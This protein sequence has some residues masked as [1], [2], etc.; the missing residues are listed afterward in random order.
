MYY[1][2]FQI[3]YLNIPFLKFLGPG[4]RP[5]YQSISR[6]RFAHEARL[7]FL[8]YT[9]FTASGTNK[10][11]RLLL[12]SGGQTHSKVASRCASAA[13][14]RCA[15]SVVG[16]SLGYL[17]VVMRGVIVVVTVL[18]VGRKV[19]GPVPPASFALACRLLSE[20]PSTAPASTS[21][22]WASLPSTSHENGRPCLH[23]DCP[24]CALSRYW[25]HSIA[26][27]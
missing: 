23:F 4:V 2:F 3:R 15:C 13:R 24:P 14:R 7:G 11:V 1:A 17:A 12:N 18:R 6:E 9:E 21:W 22:K 5:P 19:V 26:R 27:Q 25:P 16:S 8:V 10:S 20:V